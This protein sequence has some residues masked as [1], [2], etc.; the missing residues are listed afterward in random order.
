MEKVSL[1]IDN[2][3]VEAEEGTTV[4]RAAQDA[5][6]YIPALCADPDLE[7]YAGCRLCLVEIVGMEGLL[8]SCT[9]PVTEGMIVHTNTSSVNEVRRWLVELLLSDHPDNCLVCPG[10]LRCELQKVVAYLG[11][12]RPRFKK[13]KRPVYIDSSNPFF[14]RDT[15]KCILCGKCVRVCNEIQGDGAWAISN[16]GISTKIITSAGDVPVIYSTCES[17]GQCVAKCPTAALVP[18]DH[19]WS[20]KEVS[21][22]CTYCG[23]GCGLY[24]GIRGDEVIGVRGNPNSP[25]SRGRLCV[26][27]QFGFD[28]INHPNRLTT[29]L[30]RRNG[31]LVQTSWDEAL[32]LVTQKLANY[33]GDQFAF[34]SSAKCTNEENYLAQKFTRVVMQTNNVDHCARL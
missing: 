28:F 34:I 8:T 11:V 33:K 26:K 7:P 25:V 14:V 13:L 15:S 10:N 12:E 22:I 30:V 20:T 9:T 4:L 32:D 3:K 31:E 5:G 17:C 18:K 16:D 19:R 6:I 21:T 2:I 29:P 1:T 23:V 27:G 24:L